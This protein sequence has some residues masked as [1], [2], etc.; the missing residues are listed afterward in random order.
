MLKFEDK[1]DP[2]LVNFLKV[3]YTLLELVA[4]SY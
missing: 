3:A 4:S 2:H 1:I